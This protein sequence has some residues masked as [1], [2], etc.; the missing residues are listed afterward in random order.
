MTESELKR[1]L[2][3]S[4]RA[5]GGVGHRF[6]DKYSI[7]WPDC[8]FIPETGPV[9]FTEVKIIKLI[10]DPR[11]KVTEMQKVQVER[12]TREPFKG[13]YFCFGVVIGW[14]PEK[15]ALYIGRP[16]ARL[17][18]CRFVPRPSRLDSAE[19]WITE[20]L[21]KYYHDCLRG[22]NVQPVDTPV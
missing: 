8:L 20:L 21:G 10:R 6:E 11:L 15:S 19:W 7:G 4:I 9:F 17:S 5:Q 12:L 14:A 3:R 16:D 22:M 1:Y 2:I 18:E 13:N